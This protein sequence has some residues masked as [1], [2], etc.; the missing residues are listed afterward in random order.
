MPDESE[1]VCTSCGGSGIDYTWHEG[2]TVAEVHACGYCCG[3]TYSGKPVVIEWRHAD[4]LAGGC[5]FAEFC[6]MDEYMCIG[7]CK[8]SEWEDDR[9]KQI[10]SS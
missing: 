6:G 3:G 1:D 8:L 10:E 4:C 9:A 2:A 5:Q 7:R